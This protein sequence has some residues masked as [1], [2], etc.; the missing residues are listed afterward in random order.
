MANEDPKYADWVRSQP[1]CSCGADG[2]SQLH[3]MTGAGMGLRAHDHLGMP[4]CGR[5]HMEFH[6]SSGGFKHWT[7]DTKRVWQ[8]IQV[9][10]SRERYR[11]YCNFQDEKSEEEAEDGNWF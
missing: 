3:H 6:D 2:P 7:K 8:V 10:N 11:N 1:C 4:M 5:C 9:H